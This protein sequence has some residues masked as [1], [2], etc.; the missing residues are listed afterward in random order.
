MIVGQRHGQQKPPPDITSC[1]DEEMQG[2]LRFCFQSVSP[3]LERLVAWMQDRGRMPMA[4]RRQ[5]Q[6]LLIGCTKAVTGQWRETVACAELGWEQTVEWKCP[7]GREA[8]QMDSG[9][10]RC[11]PE[12]CSLP[13][14]TVRFCSKGFF[15]FGAK[16]NLQVCL[17]V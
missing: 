13:H 1:R 12:P 14:L 9:H 2:F 7:G 6:K 8:L 11:S 5:Q 17:Q 15:F 16:E 4:L 10:Y 3:T